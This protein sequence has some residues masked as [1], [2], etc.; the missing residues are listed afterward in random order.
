M[1]VTHDVAE[2]VALADRVVVIDRG[3]IALD[4]ECAAAAPAP[5]RRPGTRPAGTA[6]SRPVVFQS[7]VKARRAP[8]SPAF[9]WDLRTFLLA[10]PIR[11]HAR[12]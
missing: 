9:Y 11:R 12:S 8:L 2:A 4:L 6:N 10:R 3:R 5:A 7:T 1:L